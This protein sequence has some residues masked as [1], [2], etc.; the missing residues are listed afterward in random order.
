M[1][2]TGDLHTHTIY[3]HGKGTPRDNV[4][5]AV[6]LGLDAIAVSEHAAANMYFGVRGKKLEKLNRELDALNKEFSS[7]IRVLKGLECN[8]TD[9]GKSDIPKDR[10]EYDII[11]LGYHKG[12]PPTNRFA[13][14]ILLESFGGKSTPRRNTEAIMEAADKGRADVISHPNE[15]LRIDIE[16]MAKCARELGILLE[17]NSAHVSLSVEQLRTAA[18]HG[19]KFIIGSDAHSPQRVGDFSAALE[20]AREAEILN[21]VVNV[22]LD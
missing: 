1:R 12:V 11:I 13:R 17:I 10:S 4:L 20:A 7:R 15:Y 22:E 19:A 16:Y 2:I 9:F 14:H 8:V 5:R 18:R 21:R 6:E 3:S